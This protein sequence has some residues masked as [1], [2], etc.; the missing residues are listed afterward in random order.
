MGTTNYSHITSVQFQDNERSFVIQL[1]SEINT[2]LQSRD[3]CIKRAGGERTING[4]HFV[5]FPDVLLFSDMSQSVILQGWEAKCPDVPID[6]EA[7]VNDA[8][9]K[10]RLLNCNST[11]LWNFQYAQLHVCGEDGEFYI[12]EN[13]TISPNIINRQS[14]SLYESEWRQFAHFLIDKIAE[15]VATGSIKHRSLGDTLTGSVMPA[16]INKNKGVVSEELK[17]EAA[18]NVQVKATIENWWA[19]VKAEYVH[20]ETDPFSAYAKIILI[21]WMNKFLFANIIQS[22]CDAARVIGNITEG[23]KI[24]E[25]VDYFSRITENCDFYNVFS[26]F[27][28]SA[29][30]PCTT[31]D[32]LLS[33]NQLLLECDIT[34][35]ESDYSH[36]ILEDSISV[37][38]RQIA[39][40][41]PTP[42]P[43]AKLMSEIA[44]R[45]A[46]GHAWDCCCG[47]GTIGC[48]VWS[49][50]E[51]LLR[52][53]EPN[54]GAIAYKT[55]WMSDIHDFPLQIATQ[56]LSSLSP[57]AVPLLIFKQNVF[58]VDPG[59]RLNVVDPASGEMLE[60][61]VPQFDS[62]VS[63]LPFVDFNT[64]EI[65]WYDAVK[66]EL[67]DRLQREF[68]VALSD[69]NDLYCYIALHL[70]SLL[71]DDGYICLLTSNSWLC[72]SA[73]DNFLDAL[74]SVFSV[75]GI[76]VNGKY[77]WF[78]N[79]D[80][81]NAVL[82]LKKKGSSDPDKTHLGVIAASIADL[83]NDSIRRQ[84]SNCIIAHS[85]D[86]AFFSEKEYRWE[87]VLKYKQFGLSYYAICQG[88]SFLYEMRAGL[89]KARCK[90]DIARGTKSGQDSFFYSD[91]PTFVDDEFRLDLLKNLRGVNS[92]TLKPNAYAFYCDK[93]E[94][95]LEENGYQKTLT[96]IRSVQSINASCNS[97]RPY[98]YTLPDSKPL[99][100][101]T[102]MNT[103]G[104]LFF[105][106]APKG[107]RFVANQRVL[108]FKAK[109]PALDEELCLSL[110]NST[111]GMLLIEVSA[112]PMALGALDTRAATFRE[113][114]MLNPDL[115]SAEDREAI[116]TAFEPLKSRRV[117]EALVELDLEDRKIFDDAV[118]KAYGLEN[119]GERIRSTLKSMLES[120]LHR[121]L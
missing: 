69:R 118:L 41:Y 21:N 23:C 57:D 56:S 111:L 7:F 65:S 47:T 43:L 98:W 82:V 68:N 16:L 97:H 74:K 89:H 76:Y 12:A 85:G 119:Y 105:A 81:M 66:Q 54:P 20:D 40:Q 62:I 93:S 8:H 96:H 25:A 106:G 109:D 6:D 87:D 19:A 110:L 35:L 103:G 42:E 44:V 38:K 121:G 50:K 79:A 77:R 26:E 52:D 10:A 61:A 63:N 99:S 11:V 83:E 78:S 88:A 104:R 45:N 27:K 91:D 18:R 116:L 5:K 9:N 64:T 113:M 95:Y 28:Y 90:F 34:R 17:R 14:I 72:T 48:S 59:K 73:G 115:V 31:W 39:G 51:E 71:S 117:E 33:F 120:R 100:F 3:I 86:C 46:Y 24:S 22:R 80:V 1:I 94:D 30:L 53:I 37:A 13:W 2:Y 49:R 102:S 36:K 55:T 32:D 60:V 108:C 114:Q 15:Y 101:T 4:G 67:K 84:I 75:D 29:I 70:E 112:A 58:D 92:F 107:T